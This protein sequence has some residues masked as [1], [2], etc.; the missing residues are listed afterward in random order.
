VGLEEL[1]R[2]NSLL[3]LITG[4]AGIMGPTTGALLFARLGPHT[5]VLLVSLLYIAAVPIL[6]RVPAPRA[7]VGDAAGLSLVR[8][9]RAGL[10]YVRRTPLLV[11]LVLCAFVFCLGAG[12]VTVLDVVFVTRSLHLSSATVGQ[13]YAANGVGALLGSMAMLL[14]RGRMDQ[15][16]HLILGWAVVGVA[17]GQALYAA[18]PTLSVAVLAVGV[19]GFCFSLGLVSF[20]TLMQVSTE[21]SFMGRVM[22]ICSMTVAAGMIV[23]LSCGGILADLIG[24]RQVIGACS[25]VVGLCGVLTLALVRV[26]PAPRTATRDD[27]PR[28]TPTPAA[29]EA[30]AAG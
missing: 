6:A 22:S 7:V 17:G 3:S 13:L 18:A 24:V 16:Y 21:D 20:L 8:D 27:E 2:A 4:S 25:L 14:A 11:Y 28:P 30:T 1:G 10:G 5:T 9:I 29:L 26:T 12:A 23:S 19:V 15:R